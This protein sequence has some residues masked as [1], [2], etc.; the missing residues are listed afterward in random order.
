M[1]KGFMRHVPAGAQAVNILVGELADLDKVT[2]AFVR[3]QVYH[4][5]NN[6]I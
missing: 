5:N 3:I 4:N 6:P 2:A 1:N